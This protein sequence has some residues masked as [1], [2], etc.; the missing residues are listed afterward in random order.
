MSRTWHD[1]NIR[2]E[3][4]HGNQN[5]ESIG[6]AYRCSDRN[7]YTN[8]DTHSLTATATAGS[9][10]LAGVRMALDKKV[11]L[12]VNILVESCKIKH[13]LSQNRTRTETI[14]RT[15]YPQLQLIDP[16]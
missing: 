1:L 3:T 13:V 8:L 2:I 15:L 6:E 16:M 9:L 7:W 11:Y 12:V 10:S 5:F 14:S 4:F